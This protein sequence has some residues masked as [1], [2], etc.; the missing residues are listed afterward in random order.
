[1]ARH[2]RPRWQAQAHTA[3]LQVSTK[4][5]LTLITSTSLSQLHTTGHSQSLILV[6][7]CITFM[8]VNT[9]LWPHWIPLYSRDLKAGYMQEL[10]AAG[11]Y[12]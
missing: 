6:K 10:R 4:T 3:S 11:G 1:M 9:E 8:I 12:Y 5:R 2:W 7:V